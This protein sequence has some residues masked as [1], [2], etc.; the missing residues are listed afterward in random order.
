MS[1]KEMEMR[2]KTEALLMARQEARAKAKR[3]KK[4]SAA[5]RKKFQIAARKQWRTKMARKA[6]GSE[7]LETAKASSRTRPRGGYTILER[8]LAR[9]DPTKWYT[10]AQLVRMMPDTGKDGLHATLYQKARRLGLV[11][12]VAIPIETGLHPT[13]RI[14]APKF[15]Y[16]IGAHADKER[17]RAR[18]KELALVGSPPNG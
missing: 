16:R 7:F 2:A 5:K 14:I 13:L 11:E 17:A 9:T 3:T 1:D 8:L 18:E 12:R 4:V 15:A 10:H 6:S